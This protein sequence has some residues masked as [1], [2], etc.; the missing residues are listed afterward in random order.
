MSC[1][2]VC[3]C[4]YVCV[5]VSHVVVSISRVVCHVTGRRVQSRREALQVDHQDRCR[6]CDSH[7]AGGETGAP[8][9]AAA[10]VF[11]QLCSDVGD[12]TGCECDWC[13]VGQR[14]GN[15]DGDGKGG[16]LLR[17]RLRP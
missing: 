16:L 13:P 3:V 12:E 17:T 6:T 14:R 4:V 2:C 10:F 1:V 8:F 7:L 15:G 5:C 11:D 9:T